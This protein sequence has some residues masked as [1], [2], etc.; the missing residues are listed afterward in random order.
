MMKLFDQCFE[1]FI[2]FHINLL[3]KFNSSKHGKRD[4]WEYYLAKVAYF[5][6]PFF[7]LQVALILCSMK[8]CK[9]IL[10]ERQFL[11]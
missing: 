1:I 6:M 10:V 2:E 11:L 8:V 7:L 9:R 5:R 3:K 4:K